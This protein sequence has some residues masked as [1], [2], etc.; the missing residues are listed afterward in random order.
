MIRLRIGKQYLSLAAR[1]KILFGMSNGIILQVPNITMEE[2]ESLIIHS[3]KGNDTTIAVKTNDDG[4]LRVL[5]SPPNT[6]KDF[7]D[8]SSGELDIE[9]ELRKRIE[10]K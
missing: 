10:G 2:N 9:P 5:F 4:A 3:Y 7:I 6:R 1:L 8:V